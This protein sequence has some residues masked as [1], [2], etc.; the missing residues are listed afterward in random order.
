MSKRIVRYSKKYINSLFVLKKRWVITMLIII[1]QFVF[2]I[3]DFY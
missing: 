2:G 3:I 1:V